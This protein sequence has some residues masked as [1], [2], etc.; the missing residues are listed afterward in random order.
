MRCNNKDAMPT[1]KENGAIRCGVRG[2]YG[3]WSHE[4]VLNELPRLPGAPLSGQTKDPEGMCH[5]FIFP[6]A[7]HVYLCAFF[8]FPFFTFCLFCQFF[9]TFFP[10][11][12]TSPAYC[13]FWQK[14]QILFQ[15]C[16]FLHKSEI[17]FQKCFFFTRCFFLTEIWKRTVKKGTGLYIFYLKFSKK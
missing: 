6:F 1:P 9:E 2:S 14:P 16:L 8:L 11:Q 15:K 3:R 12:Y 10:F 17:L 13:F 7:I 5:L 4:H